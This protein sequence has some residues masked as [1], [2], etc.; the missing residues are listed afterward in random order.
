MLNERQQVVRILSCDAAPRELI[1]SQLLPRWLVRQ[2]Q[3]HGRRRNSS[4]N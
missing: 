2:Q 1:V 4:A 3:D